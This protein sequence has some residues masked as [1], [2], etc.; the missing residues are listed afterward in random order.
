MVQ[1]FRE[2]GHPI[3]TSTSALSRGI[4]KQR[5]GKSTIHFNGES[6]KFGTLV[7][8]SLVG[9]SSQYLRGRRGLV[10]SI[11]FDQ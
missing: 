8:N 4:L 1:Q 3:F 10:L 11:R 2:T 9:E 7:L 6:V 5:K